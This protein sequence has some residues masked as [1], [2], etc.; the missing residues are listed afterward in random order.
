M[1]LLQIGHKRA[2][3]FSSDT[4]RMVYPMLDRYERVKAQKGCFD[5][6]D[7][8]ASVYRRLKA[9]GYP[10]TPIH[11]LFRDEVQDFTQAEL[12]LDFR[13]VQRIQLG[14]HCTCFISK[15]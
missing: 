10:G 7:L 1:G 12:L 14:L 3:N 11:E 2:P 6:M 15:T 9:G 4:R 5:V 8:A 13:C